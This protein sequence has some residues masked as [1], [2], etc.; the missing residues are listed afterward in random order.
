MAEEGFCPTCKCNVVIT[1]QGN[2]PLG[3]AIDAA[4]VQPPPQT[5]PAPEP[6]PV[7]EPAPAPVAAATG[8]VVAGAAV[9]ATTTGVP[10]PADDTS[11]PPTPTGDTST[12]PP[13]EESDFLSGPAPAPAHDKDSKRKLS[14]VLIILLVL[15][16][17]MALAAAAIFVFAPDVFGMDTANPTPIEA[18]AAENSETA[19][20]EEP[21]AQDMASAYDLSP[22]YGGNFQWHTGNPNAAF[23]YIVFLNDTEADLA[24][25]GHTVDDA[26][27][28]TWVLERDMLT[29]V[30][31]DGVSA[32]ARILELSE[33]VL[34]IEGQASYSP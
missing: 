20:A 26:T 19:A 5:A 31:P 21:V 9:A 7:P 25:P 27:R 14:P 2:C 23:G 28:G 33:T 29:L 22:Y 11:I 34:V 24:V 1:Q 12:L 18:P 15:I 30:Q 13:P 16:L 32:T 10:T 4:E 3:H 8:A 17:V 6:T